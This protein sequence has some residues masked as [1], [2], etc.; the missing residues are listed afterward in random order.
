MAHRVGLELLDK[1]LIP[2]V[3][4]R[5]AARLPPKAIPDIVRCDDTR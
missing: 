2:G 5:I 3:F 1:V 4:F